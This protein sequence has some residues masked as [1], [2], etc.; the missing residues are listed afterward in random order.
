MTASAPSAAHVDHGLEPIDV[1]QFAEGKTSRDRL[2]LTVNYGFMIILSLIFIA[3]ILYLLIGSLK[4][5]N[6]VLNGLAGFLPVDIS[7]DNY[8][9]VWDRFNSDST[10]YFWSFYMISAIVSGVIVVVGV[11]VNAL[12]AYAIARLQW[13][14][15]NAILAAI[16]IL[17]ILPFEAIVV[18]LFYMLNDFRNTIEVLFIPFIANAFSIYL[19]YSFFIGL[20]RQIEEAARSDGAGPW[21]TFGLIVV[22]M[23]RPVFATVAILQFLAAWGMYLWPVMMISQPNKRPLPLALATFRGLPPFDWGQIFAFGVLLVLPVLLV[24]LVF[25]RWFIQSVATSGLKG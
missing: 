25:Q 12:A 20:P 22:P 11:V 15:R 13:R 9:G 1:D 2:R 10:G 8:S 18:P 16:V 17:V 14:G 7:L 6:E 19:F 21:K 4:P 23:S 3:P 24:F 5:S